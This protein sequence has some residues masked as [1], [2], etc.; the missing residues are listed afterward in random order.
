MNQVAVEIGEL[1]RS[2]RESRGTSVDQASLALKI[3]VKYLCALEEGKS[4]EQPSVVYLLGYLKSYA[5]YL[6]LNSDQ[7]IERF[8]SEKDNAPSHPELYLPEPYRKDFHPRPV[9]LVLSLVLVC[10]IYGGW[11]H[12]HKEGSFI[13]NSTRAISDELS[14]SSYSNKPNI[15]LK[16]LA[17]TAYPASLP[18]ANQN[19]SSFRETVQEGA[20]IVLLAKTST[21]IK[22]MDSNSRLLAERMLNAGDTYF[23]SDEKGI[24]ITA[25]NPDAIEVMRDGQF[26]ELHALNL[27]QSSA[28][29]KI[30][31]SRFMSSAR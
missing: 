8:R 5:D 27:Q 18:L 20:S 13:R 3:R 11:H 25:G 14:V 15:P 10:V 30:L 17:I 7:V 1:L 19:V 9:A 12:Y 29:G 28:S 16:S 31:V 24:V 2:T 6:G 4:A 23:V 22:I 21:W 26:S